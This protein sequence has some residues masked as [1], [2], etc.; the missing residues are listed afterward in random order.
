MA[1]RSVDSR[2]NAETHPRIVRAQPPGARRRSDLALPVPRAGSECAVREER[3]CSPHAVVLA[4]VRSK[5]ESVVPIPG[6]R[7]PEH[8]VD[9]ARSVEVV[10]TTEEVEEIDRSEFSRA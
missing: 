8:A 5:G 2:R 4:W 10:L 9:S 1:G 6:A 3:G 7:S